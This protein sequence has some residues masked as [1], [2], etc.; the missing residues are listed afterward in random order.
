MK[1]C[2]DRRAH[3]PS[4]FAFVTINKI[5]LSVAFAGDHQP[6][7]KA[8][9]YINLSS[10]IMKDISLSGTGFPSLLL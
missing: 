6:L 8:G 5:I 1:H 2:R 9:I 7:G 10:M 4:T 3:E